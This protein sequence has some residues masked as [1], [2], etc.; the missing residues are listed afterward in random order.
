MNEPNQNPSPRWWTVPELAS[1]NGTRSGSTRLGGSWVSDVFFTAYL[2]ATDDRPS[3]RLLAFYRS[4]HACTRARLAL[5]HL[6]DTPLR[7]P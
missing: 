1:W 7:T 4:W 5:L 6:R 3:P 2:D